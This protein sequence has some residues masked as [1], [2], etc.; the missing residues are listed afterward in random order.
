MAHAVANFTHFPTVR[1][2][3][4]EACRWKVSTYR[5]PTIL[6]TFGQGDQSY[7]FEL[8]RLESD[9]PI[10]WQHICDPDWAAYLEFQRAKP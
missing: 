3:P 2:K 1:R 10:L 6:L 8:H 9:P 7:A 4:S 5:K